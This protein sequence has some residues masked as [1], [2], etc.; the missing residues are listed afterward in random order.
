MNNVNTNQNYNI[1][2]HIEELVLDGLP[3]QDQNRI[4]SAVQGE[5]HRLLSQ[6]E[7]PAIL[8]HNGSIGRLNGSSFQIERGATAE[9]IGKQVAQSLYGGL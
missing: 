3:V 4:T 6:G 9:V 7:L 2:V 5:L 8:K 1:S